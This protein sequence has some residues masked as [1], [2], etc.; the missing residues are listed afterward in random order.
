MDGEEDCTYDEC[1][2]ANLGESEPGSLETVEDLWELSEREVP[3]GLLGDW[4]KA[5]GTK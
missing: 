2:D 1:V 5:R 3:I 4:R